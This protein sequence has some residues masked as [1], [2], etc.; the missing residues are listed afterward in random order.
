[1]VMELSGLL[2]A[3]TGLDRPPLHCVLMLHIQRGRDSVA[4]GKEGETDIVGSRL[5]A[6]LMPLP[7]SW[8]GFLVSKLNGYS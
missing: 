7:A 8:Q 1:M 4:D 2:E 5:A 6:K 3:Q